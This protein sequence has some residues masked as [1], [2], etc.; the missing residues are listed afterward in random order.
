M[1]EPGP[2]IADRYWDAVC[3]AAADEVGRDVASGTNLVPA[4]SRDGSNLVVV[5]P[6]PGFT[7]IWCSP[8]LGPQLNRL[9]GDRALTLD[10]S[11][12]ACTGLGG[13]FFATGTHRILLD[14]L[15]PPDEAA[16]ALAPLDRDRP[17]HVA[18][19]R[20]FLGECSDD[21]ID[22][23]EIELDGLDPAITVTQDEQG[24]IAA[25]ASARAWH[26][27]D[28]FDDIGVLVHP[29]CRKQGLGKL[30]VHGLAQRQQAAGR[31]PLYN[32]GDENE[33]SHGVATAVGFRYL[34]TV[35]GIMFAD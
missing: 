7:L 8:H 5:Y 16:A 30:V 22:E 17:D 18:L 3:S 2:W 1:Y 27:D 20:S 14:R 33:G 23:A 32:Y 35:A 10:E 21:D 11:V 25:F 28:E 31:F 12:E 26:Y 15:D 13:E 24:H 4:A 6:G 29:D 19:I 34:M 9:N